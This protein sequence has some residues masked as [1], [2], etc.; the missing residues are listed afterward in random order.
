VLLR[1]S[2]QC[3]HLEC[4]ELQKLLDCI[5]PS[6]SDRRKVHICRSV[7]TRASGGGPLIPW[8]AHGT[9]FLCGTNRRFCFLSLRSAR[10]ASYLRCLRELM[11][12]RNSSS[13]GRASGCRLGHQCGC[14]LGRYPDKRLWKRKFGCLVLCIVIFFRFG[15]V[16]CARLDQLIPSVGRQN[17][18]V[19]AYSTPY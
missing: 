10:H 6:S 14:V 7:A 8:T 4:H 11:E 2:P 3:T 9:L 15:K 12:S 16:G 18:L 19:T 17:S 1:G 5:S 13:L